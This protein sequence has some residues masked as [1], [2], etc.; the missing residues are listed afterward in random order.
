M[1]RRFGL[2]AALCSA[3]ALGGCAATAPEGALIADPYES[4]N[5]DIHSF[6]VGMDQVLLRPTT[7]IYR[8]ATP[9][10]VQH[11]VGNAVDT[12]RMPVIIFN[13]AFQ[14]NFDAALESTGR[15]RR[16]SDHGPR[17]ARSR[18]GNRPAARADRWRLTFA[19]YGAD[20]G[21]YLVSP[22]LGPFTS[23]DFAGRVLDFVIDPTN[24]I[25]FPGGAGAAAARIAVPIVDAR[26][27]N[28]DLIDEALYESEDSY[29]TVRTGYVLNRR[30]AAA[31]ARGD[32]QTT[33]LP[34]IYAE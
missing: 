7:Y 2:A 15:L 27:E 10:L 20:E 9:A 24:F 19:R 12:L 23:R 1:S 16:E 18:Y 34:D 6:N 28:F 21:V 30:R 25:R 3:I 5:R 11:L 31:Q 14:G 33:T 13:H 26:S 4:L 17:R 22:F 8:E 32:A 29:V